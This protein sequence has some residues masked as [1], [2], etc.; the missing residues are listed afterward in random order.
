[1]L[2]R[3]PME[4]VSMSQVISG[5]QAGMDLVFDVF[6]TETCHCQFDFRSLSGT[7]AQANLCAPLHSQHSGKHALTY[8]YSDARLSSTQHHVVC[9]WRA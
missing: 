7:P 3:F 6:I 4:C 1:M 9:I 5:L 8:I 2:Y